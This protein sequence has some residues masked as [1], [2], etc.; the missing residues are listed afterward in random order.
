MV[1]DGSPVY[2]AAERVGRAS[3]S[4]VQDEIITMDAIDTGALYHSMDYRIHSSG[5]KIFVDVGPY[6][7]GHGRT[8]TP[9]LEYAKYVHDGSIHNKPPKPYIANA[10]KKVRDSDWY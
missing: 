1:R 3:L 10:L 4:Y 7:P 5:D 8:G 6:R 9:T 2:I